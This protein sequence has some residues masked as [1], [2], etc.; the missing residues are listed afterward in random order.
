MLEIIIS[1]RGGQGVVLASQILAA[2]FFKN[3]QK[4]Q[5][6]PSFGAERRGAPVSA[7]VRVDSAEMTLRCNVYRADW[8]VLLDA[9]SLEN[10]TLVSS[11]KEGG[12]LLVNGTVVP[13]SFEKPPKAGLFMVD[14]RAIALRLHL[15]GVLSP[16]MNTAMTGAFARASALV[17]L[18]SVIEAIREMVPAEKER[19]ATAAAEAYEAVKQMTPAQTGKGSL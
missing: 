7:F 12:A 6:F 5:A 8:I 17:P 18:D 4:V 1:G 11:L 15:G 19:N 9:Q 14:A 2:A 3:G 16:I 13:E 10:S